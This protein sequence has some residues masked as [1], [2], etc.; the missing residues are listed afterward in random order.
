MTLVHLVKLFA[1]NHAFHAFTIATDVVSVVVVAGN[2]CD[3]LAYVMLSDAF[4]L[5]SNVGIVLA[6]VFGHYF[7]FMRCLNS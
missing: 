2:I 3:V 6:F 1:L 7:D 5:S 4:V